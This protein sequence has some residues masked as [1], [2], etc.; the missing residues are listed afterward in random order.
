[1]L[2]SITQFALVEPHR[3]QQHATL[4]QTPFPSPSPLPFPPFPSCSETRQ[5]KFTFR[6]GTRVGVLQV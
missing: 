6:R 5:S 4:Y 3:N 1:M 2:V